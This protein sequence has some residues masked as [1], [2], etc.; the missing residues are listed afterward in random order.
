M[1]RGANQRPDR[2]DQRGFTLVEMMTVAAIVALMAAMA[3]PAFSRMVARNEVQKAARGIAATLQTSRLLAMNQNATVAVVPSLVPGI[4][5]QSLSVAVLNAN[6]GLP[7]THPVTGAP[8]SAGLQ[9]KAT[10]VTALTDAGG[11]PVTPANFGPQGLLAPI[12]APALVWTIANAPQNIVYSVTVSPGGR[13]RWCEM[14]VAP[15]G[16]CQ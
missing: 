7:L 15:G 10:N 3:A 2:R 13:V 8:I 9:E 14:A 6:T 16:V 4:D 1:R 5:G 11:G 12:G